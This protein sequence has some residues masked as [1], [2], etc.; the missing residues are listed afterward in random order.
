[1][2]QEGK[3]TRLANRTLFLPISPNSLTPIL[4]RGREATGPA[5]GPFAGYYRQKLPASHRRG[6][7]QSNRLA[8]ASAIQEE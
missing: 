7:T 6:R 4:T 1:M 2:S 3:E 8:T 5:W